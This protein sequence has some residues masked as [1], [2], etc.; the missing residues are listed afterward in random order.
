VVKH[1]QLARQV[2]SFADNHQ[3]NSTAPLDNNVVPTRGTT[4]Y[5]GSWVFI[6]DGLGG[7]DSHLIDLGTPE[8]SEATQHREVNNFIDQLD[9]IPLP[10]HVKEDQNQTDFDVNLPKSLS[11]MEEK[12]DNLLEISRQEVIVNREL[13]C[14]N[15]I[16]TLSRIAQNSQPTRFTHYDR[17]LLEGSNGNPVLASRQL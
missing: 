13:P 9:E 16:R 12:L 8:N 1:R 17:E 3:K 2:G 14:L 6:A 10:V 11:E 7:F 4:F 15:S 5:V